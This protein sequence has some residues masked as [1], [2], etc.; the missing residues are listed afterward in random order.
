MA[1]EADRLAKAL[2]PHLIG[3]GFTNRGLTECGWFAFLASKPA[4][5][6]SA[7]GL[8][9]E[10]MLF[11]CGAGKLPHMRV[12]CLRALLAFLKMELGI[13]PDAED[14]ED[15]KELFDETPPDEHGIANWFHE[16]YGD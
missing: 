13:F 16:V 1:S 8:A 6:D 5:T 12:N 4:N 9:A 3:A 10:G 11:M 14:L 7:V 15:L 2:Y